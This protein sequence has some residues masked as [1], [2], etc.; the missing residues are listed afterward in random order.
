MACMR[1]WLSYAPVLNAT[2]PTY[3][4]ALVSAMLQLLYYVTLVGGRQPSRSFIKVN[5][6]P[7]IRPDQF[8]DQG[9]L[10]DVLF[11]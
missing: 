3:V 5:H 10:W 9:R 2:A 11:L 4:A 1:I 8:L 6:V 7:Q